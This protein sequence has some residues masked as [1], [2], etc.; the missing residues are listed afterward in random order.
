MITMFNKQK[1]RIDAMVKHQMQQQ[2][3][4]NDQMEA[5]MQQLLTT[6]DHSQ[7]ST[8]M[9]APFATPSPAPMQYPHLPYPPIPTNT[10]TRMPPLQPLHMLKTPATIGRFSTQP[11]TQQNM[12]P[13]NK[14]LQSQGSLDYQGEHLTQNDHIEHKMDLGADSNEK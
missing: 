4:Q 14:T 1:E 7:R 11:Y 5:M 12:S 6:K 3:E 13:S 10:Q 8:P 9:M 2:K